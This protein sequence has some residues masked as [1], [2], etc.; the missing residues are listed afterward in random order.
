MSK[1]FNIESNGGYNVTG[2]AVHGDRR[3]EQR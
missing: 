1:Y 3:K 2:L